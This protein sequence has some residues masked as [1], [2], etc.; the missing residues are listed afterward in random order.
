VLQVVKTV[1]TVAVIA[2]LTVGE[3]FTVAA[4]SKQAL[5][6]PA[7]RKPPQHTAY[8]STNGKPTQNT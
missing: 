7:S 8:T 5:N 6:S 1:A 3:T 4:T 2:E